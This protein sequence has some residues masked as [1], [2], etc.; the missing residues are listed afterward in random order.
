MLLSVFNGPRPG[1][2][3]LE[4]IDRVERLEGIDELLELLAVCCLP[5]VVLLM[6]DSDAAGGTVSALRIPITPR[7]S[8]F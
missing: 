6:A 7:N 2:K 1:T 4:L 5:S 3:L 8:P